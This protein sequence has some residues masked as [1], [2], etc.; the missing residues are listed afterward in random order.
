MDQAFI[1]DKPVN[2]KNFLGRK[3]EISILGNLLSSGEN[4]CI[5]EPPKSG[6]S[7]L[8]QQT[9]FNLRSKGNDFVITNINLFNS[10]S[11]EEICLNLGNSIIKSFASTPDEYKKIIE[12][13]LSGTHLIFDP[14]AYS[15]NNTIISPN[16]ALDEDDCIALMYLPFR[17]SSQSGKRLYVIIEEF[18]NVLLSEDPDRFCKL[19]ENIIKEM[20]STIDCLASFIFC[21]SQVNAM[22]EIFEHKK[23]FYRLAEHIELGEVDENEIVDFI[24]KTML[25]SGKV[26]DRDLFLGACRLFQGKLWYINHF[27]HLCDSLSKGYIMEPVLVEALNQILCVHTPAFISKMYDLT[28]YQLCLLKAICEGHDKLSTAEVIEHYNLNSSA[29]VRRLKDALCKKEIIS[30]DDHDNPYFLD[31]LFEYWVKKYYFG[32][33]I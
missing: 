2:G 16:W 26:T 14:N 13:F 19:L 28:G 17:L 27:A 1:F 30:F 11:L 6:V 9:F 3:V 7:S 15:L 8:L 22:K 10:R 25:S 31:P 32:I 18:Q 4:I 33:K 29:N 23:Y 24:V 5:Y 20:K 12:L 21:G